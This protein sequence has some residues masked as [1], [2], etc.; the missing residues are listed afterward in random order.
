MH[1]I[2]DNKVTFNVAERTISDEKNQHIL[3][4]PACRLL[5]VLLE[6]NNK[7]ITRE[8]L[9]QK[10]WGDF[11]LIPSGNSLNNNISILRKIFADF[12]IRDVL[13]TIP[14]Q[15][16]ELAI[17]E[18]QF[19]EK[20]RDYMVMQAISQPEKE[21]DVG[22]TFQTK[23]LS[24]IFIIFAVLAAS[25]FIF[26][27]RND[28]VHF[29]KQVKQCSVY[30][31]DNVNRKRVE[32]FFAEKEGAS[33][34]ENCTTPTKLYYDDSKIDEKTN[35]LDIFVAKCTVESKGDMGECHNFV[36]TKIR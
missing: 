13:K 30:Y 32:Q 16:F 8:A 31:L 24:V 14:K 17:A 26:F 23:V 15:G 27:D 4:N 28:D 9:L 18:L 2:L 21:P 29:Y 20:S 3:S 10:V 7:L 36:T 6:N 33:L 1:F 25:Y 35:L 11:G 34:L 12:G 19:S 22:M 5:L